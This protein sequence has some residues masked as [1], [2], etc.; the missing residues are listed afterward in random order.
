M[1]EEWAKDQADQI[2]ALYGELQGRYEREANKKLFG[3]P[4]LP[5]LEAFNTLTWL[6]DE[7]EKEKSGGLESKVRGTAPSG[8]F[9]LTSQKSVIAL[10]A[11]IAGVLLLY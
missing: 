11:I 3:G 1:V 6:I 2:T 4:Q 5:Y 9:N 7:Q 10:T 8:L